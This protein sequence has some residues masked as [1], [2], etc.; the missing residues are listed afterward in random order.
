M[1]NIQRINAGTDLPTIGQVQE[2]SKVYFMQAL[3]Y[4]LKAHEMNPKRR[5]TLLGLE[6]IH[7]SLQDIDKSEEYRHK[8]EA[9]DQEAPPE[10]PRETPKDK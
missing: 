7:Y 5:E 3:P 10:S 4:M 1:Y 8:Y 6:G 2:V 9:L